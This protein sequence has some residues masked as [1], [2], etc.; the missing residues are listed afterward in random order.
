M[1]LQKVPYTLPLAQGMQQKKDPKTL[2]GGISLVENGIHRKDQELKKRFGWTSLPRLLSDGVT[3]ITEADA[4]AVYKEELLI[5]SKNHLYTWS[6]AQD[7]WY[8]RG[9]AYSV[10]IKTRQIIANNSNYQFADSAY[11]D[12]V[13]LVTYEFQSAVWYQTYDYVTGAVLKGDTELAPGAARPKCVSI[14]GLLYVIYTDTASV[15]IIGQIINP[16]TGNVTS[17]VTLATDNTFSFCFDVFAIAADTIMLAYAS[18]A[19]IKVKFLNTALGPRGAPYTDTTTAAGSPNF[20]RLVPLSGGRVAIAYSTGVAGSTVQARVV[21]STGSVGSAINTGLVVDVE[22]GEIFEITGHE[23]G[24]D[25]RLYVHYNLAATSDRVVYKA[26][27]STSGGANTSAMFIRSAGIAIRGFMHEGV[28]FVGIYHKSTLQDTLFIVDEQGV[29]I[30]RHQPGTFGTAFDK[31]IS[32]PW[33]AVSGRYEFA[34]TNKTRVITI[35]DTNTLYTF[36]GNASPS[37]SNLYSPLNVAVTS[38]DFQDNSNFSA[39]EAGDSLLVVGGALSM[40]DSI[41][42]VEHG[43]LIYPEKMS[44]ALVATGSI[45]NGDYLYVACYEWTDANGLLHRSTPSVPLKVTM[46]GGPKGI[47]V[48]VD[49]LRI[50]QKK[51]PRANVMISL[52]RTQ[53]NQTGPFYRVTSLQTPPNNSVTVDSVVIHDTLAD[54]S[55]PGR[56]FLYTT[57]GVLDNAA[58]YAAK[59]MSNWRGRIMLTGGEDNIVQYSKPFVKGAPVEFSVENTLE[60]ETFGGDPTALEILDDKLIL[61]KKE[62][63]YHTFGDG[64]DATGTVGG[65]APFTYISTCDVGCIDQQSTCPRPGGVIFKSLKGYYELGSNLMSSYIGAD[66]EDY[67]SLFV[68]SSTLFSQENEIRITNKDGVTL[69]YNYFFQKWSVFTNYEAADGLKWMQSFVHV[70]ADGRVCIET[71]G[72]WRDDGSNYDLKI[73]TGWQSL[74]DIAGFQRVYRAQ[75]VG[76]YHTKVTLSMRTAY[77]FK[78]TFIDSGFFDLTGVEWRWQFPMKQQKCESIRYE[79]T[80]AVT[81][82]LESGEGLSFTSMSLLFGVKPGLTRVKNALK[83]PLTVIP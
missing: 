79:I 65:F 38:V 8:D 46:S 37:S 24:L 82:L 70:K 20:L 81:D 12:G 77:D 42:V 11:A 40:Y 29:V 39:T 25:L 63:A 67:N 55:L 62:R 13:V 27:V 32:T 36:S 50:T 4:G 64:P 9:A 78:P 26:D 73:L 44:A 10:A 52:F 18:G 35:T 5:W 57:G 59:F 56:E 49:T 41:S 61:F 43:F 71:P 58:A 47:D 80:A 14:G 54:G 74:A 19:N 66:V 48:T 15:N 17:T 68:S 6:E 21:S 51:P 23:R 28:G 1:P 30:S 22:S 75:I 33:S 34:I 2:T 45:A 53:V 31:N 16:A 83:A 3:S 76:E 60:I 72:S 69:V 7:Y